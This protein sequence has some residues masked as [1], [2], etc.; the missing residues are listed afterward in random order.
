MVTKKVKFNFSDNIQ[1]NV[2]KFCN[3]AMRYDFDMDLVSGRYVIDAKSIMGIFSLSLANPINLNI[4]VDNA[5]ECEQF[6]NDIS[7]FL[8]D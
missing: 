7:E 2:Q 3:V 6:L 4:L 1:E 5:S 8:V